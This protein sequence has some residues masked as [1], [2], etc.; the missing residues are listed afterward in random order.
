MATLEAELAGLDALELAVPPKK[1]RAARIW[2]ALWP[3][4]GAVAIALA[5]WQLV[6]MSGWRSEVVGS[7]VFR[8]DLSTVAVAEETDE[9]VAFLLSDRFPQD[10]EVRKARQIVEAFARQPDA[11]VLSIDNAMVD[12]PHLRKAERLLA[13]AAT[14]RR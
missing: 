11:G 13:R 3:K 14:I 9:V 4:L 12:R 10:D 6:Y 1:S 7:S 5:F 8:P 2:S